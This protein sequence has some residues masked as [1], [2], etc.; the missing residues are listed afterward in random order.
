MMSW[1]Q[2]R[3]WIYGA[4]VVLIALDVT[5]YALWLRAPL[6]PGATNAGGILLLQREVDKLAAEVARL[7][8]VK[9][10]LPGL[11]PQI[12]TFNAERLLPSATGFSEM[13]AD[14]QR[15]AATA[16]V[17][18][19]RI[20]YRLGNVE[21]LSDLGRIEVS[22]SVQGSYDRLLR[23]IESLERSTRL[24]VIEDVEVGGT[25]TRELRLEMK[26]SAYVH[27]GAG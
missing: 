22:T 3:W 4:L 21:E 26:L 27:R 12:K 7:Q 14:L 17:A 23:Y 13:A 9:D 19:P 5:L 15:A 10:H 18:L 24:Y 8:Q 6:D 11:S 2:R 25:A 20:D 16:G 1:Y